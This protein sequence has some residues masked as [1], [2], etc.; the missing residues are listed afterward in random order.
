MKDDQVAS[1][2][3]T[4]IRQTIWNTLSGQILTSELLDSI[5]KFDGNPEDSFQ[6]LVLGKVPEIGPYRVSPDCHPFFR[7]VPGR[8]MSQL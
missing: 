6:G 2:I 1:L 4:G 7:V 3:T 5:E 8:A